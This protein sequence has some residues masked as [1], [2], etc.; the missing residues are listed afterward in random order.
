MKLENEKYSTWRVFENFGEHVRVWLI[1]ANP[2]DRTLEK[3]MR[4]ALSF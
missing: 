4:D 3:L 2:D 1:V